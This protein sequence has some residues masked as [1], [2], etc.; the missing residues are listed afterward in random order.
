MCR[1]SPF[2]LCP[3]LR[4]LQSGCLH[5]TFFWCVCLSGIHYFRKPVLFRRFHTFLTSGAPPCS[6]IML[7][8]FILLIQIAEA[9]HI[10]LRSNIR[11]Y[12]TA[13]VCNTSINFG[14]CGPGG[15]GGHGCG[16]GA[17]WG[18]GVS[19][20]S[21]AARAGTDASGA[22]LA[23]ISP[24]PRGLSGRQIWSCSCR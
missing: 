15:S 3:L 20:C 7:S 6:M 16:R 22:H 18:S 13:A 24:R 23:L 10:S 9:V 8:L 12:I 17:A 11:D 14:P 4:F 19:G 2:L 1:L 21:R 5:S